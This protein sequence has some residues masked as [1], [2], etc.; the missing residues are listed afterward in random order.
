MYCITQESNWNETGFLGCHNAGNT[1]PGYTSPAVRK[2][3][4][5]STGAIPT[6][7]YTKC[8]LV[9][10][11]EAEPAPEGEAE[12]EVVGRGESHQGGHLDRRSG[13]H[14]PAILSTRRIQSIQSSDLYF[15]NLT[16]G[17]FLNNDKLE[18]N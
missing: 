15:W 13:N 3:G 9:K 11:Q 4:I 12:G 2:I 8:R 7:I 10:N 17:Q 16:N 14:P 6:P 1:L 5:S 18:I